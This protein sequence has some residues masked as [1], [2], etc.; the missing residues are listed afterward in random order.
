M[1]KKLDGLTVTLIRQAGE[2]GQL[3]GS[4][5]GRDLSTAVTDAGIRVDRRQIEL[6]KAI[7]M[8]GLH[9]VRVRL[10]PEVVVS[11]TANVARSEE[12]AEAQIETGHVV[13]AE[14]QREAEEALVEAVIAEVEAEEEIAAESDAPADEAGETPAEEENRS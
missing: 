11:I 7:K 14:E 1:A 8:L 3:Y 4:V 2:S 5:T 9:P 6:E 10:H 12:E 13:S